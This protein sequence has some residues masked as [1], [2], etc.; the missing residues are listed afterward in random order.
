M[1]DF[2]YKTW[3]HSN[4]DSYTL[5]ATNMVLTDESADNYFDLIIWSLLNTLQHLKEIY[6]LQQITCLP[7]VTGSN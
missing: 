5:R 4:F 3:V 7:I 1:T 6:H 2:H